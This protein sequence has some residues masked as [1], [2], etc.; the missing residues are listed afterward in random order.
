[1]EKE[2]LKNGEG[3]RPHGKNLVLDGW[4]SKDLM[5]NFLS[6]QRYFSTM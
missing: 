4:T 6:G 3:D 2:I 1:M 5:P